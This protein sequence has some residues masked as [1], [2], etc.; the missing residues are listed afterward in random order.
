MRRIALLA[1]IAGFLF[2][3]MASVPANAQATRTWVSGVGDD[4]NPCSR[5]APCKTFA[6]AI[7]KTA[8]P[9]EID[10]LDPGGFGTLT[11]TRSM[12]I[13]C[14][15]TFGSILASGTTGINI[16]D[17]GGSPGTAVVL[18]RGLSING[19]GTTP[20][21]Y[22]IHFVSGLSL[23]VENCAIY[24][25]TSSPGLG[26]AFNPGTAATLDVIDTLVGQNGT[27]ASGGGIQ[28]APSNNTATAVAMLNNVKLAKNAVGAAAVGQG[29]AAA[30]Q[31]INS[32]ISNGS[33]TALIAI[34]AGATIRI[35]R[36]A[37]IN[38][39]GGSINGNV[40]SYLDNQMVGNS[41]NTA[42]ASA[43]GYQ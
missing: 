4:A 21:T 19:A 7:S 3:L 33:N 10:C 43:G 11:I 16:N 8:S 25:F 6:G 41:P 2:P 9:G 31:I 18:L 42:P 37:I 22:G 14:T 23:V 5:T 12:T 38:N 29:G 26:I 17:G 35:G 36:S 39:A 20:G 13:D 32:V 28:V 15:G 40:L 24:G 1:I 34:G 30:I 27:P